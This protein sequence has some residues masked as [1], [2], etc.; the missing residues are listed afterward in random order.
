MNS[1]SKTA[2]WV[3]GITVAVIVA[4]YWLFYNSDNMGVLGDVTQTIDDAF[5]AVVAK[6][7]RLT[8]APYDT[9]TGLVPGNPDDLAASCGLDTETYSLARAIASEEEGGNPT[10]KIAIGW[11]IKNY[12]DSKGYGSITTA[13]TTVDGYYGIQTK[14]GYCSTARDPYQGD[15]DI[16]AGILN[17][18]YSDPTGGAIQFDDFK[19]GPPANVVANRTKAGEVSEPDPGGSP[20]LE[21]WKKV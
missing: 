18:Q 4:Y 21:F 15:A 3:L 7:S 6:G 1:A 10:T 8:N 20:T 19:N 2:L 12:S 9:S 14:V 17:G 11:A 5:N 13:V 16:A